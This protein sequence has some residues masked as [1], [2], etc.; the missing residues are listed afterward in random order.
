MRVDFTRI[1]VLK[2]YNNFS[3]FKVLESVIIFVFVFSVL[4]FAIMRIIKDKERNYSL[5]CG[6]DACIAVNSFSACFV[7]SGGMS[8]YEGYCVK[9]KYI[10]QQTYNIIP[11][12]YD[13]VL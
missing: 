7:G 10:Q 1:I 5:W 8:A 4:F 9:N 11:C 13:A 12:L 6:R 2:K 3:E